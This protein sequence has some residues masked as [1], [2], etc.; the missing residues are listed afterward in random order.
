MSTET[1][2]RHTSPISTVSSRKSSSV[3]SIVASS[4]SNELGFSSSSSLFDRINM[5]ISK[6]IVLKKNL[7]KMI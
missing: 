7:I 6:F 5:E 2:F 3:K 1:W 4:T